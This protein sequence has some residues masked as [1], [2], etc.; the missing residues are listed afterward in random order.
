[1]RACPSSAMAK[2]GRGRQR[3]CTQRCA[4]RCG[5][6]GGGSWGVAAWAASRAGAAW[7]AAAERA[8]MAII[9]WRLRPMCEAPWRPV[10][11]RP[12]QP[13]RKVFSWLRDTAVEA[14]VRCERSCREGVA[15]PAAHAVQSHTGFPPAA[16]AQR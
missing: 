1:M 13:L 11:P 4:Q 15:C 5:G 14:K 10:Q 16:A 3:A 2:P 12:G 7:A 6:S 9:V 8:P